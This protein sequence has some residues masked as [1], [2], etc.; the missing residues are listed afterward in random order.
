MIQF[1]EEFKIRILST[2]PVFFKRI[3]LAGAAISATC[4]AVVAIPSVYP[5][6]AVSGNLVAICSHCLVA[7]VIMVSVSSLAKTDI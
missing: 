1:I 7:G 3:R 5:G 2:T 6:A 4:S